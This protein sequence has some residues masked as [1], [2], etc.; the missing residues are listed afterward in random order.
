MHMMIEQV[1]TGYTNLDIF[2]EK[3]QGDY[4]LQDYIRTLVPNEAKSNPSHNFWQVVPYESLQ[5]NNFD[6]Y[7]FLFWALHA[8]NR[9]ARNLNIFNRL[10]K[11]Y[12]YH[13][14]NI[15]C[16]SRYESEF[17]IYLDVIKDCFDGPDVRE[18]V[19]QIINCSL[20][21]CSKAQRKKSAQLA[22]IEQ[23]H[24][25]KNKRPRWI[26]GPEWP[27]GSNSPMAF[28]SQKRNGNAVCYEFVDVDTGET[29]VVKQFY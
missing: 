27:L 4:N 22:I 28:V 3:L 21:Y 17:D 12:L 6:Y 7:Q 29:K 14:P 19:E 5:R 1:L 11:L 13:F 2:L 10:R 15:Q 16:T 26:Q 25:V 20:Q 18:T 24:V 9:F 23:F 8:N